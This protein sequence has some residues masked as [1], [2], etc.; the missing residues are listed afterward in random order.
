[1]SLQTLQVTQVYAF[2]QSF[3]IKKMLKYEH[4]WGGLAK[5]VE[6]TSEALFESAKKKLRD[7]FIPRN[8]LVFPVI[9]Q[10]A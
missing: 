6:T 3:M 8:A 2:A 7:D 4:I 1:M 5:V 10:A 9:E